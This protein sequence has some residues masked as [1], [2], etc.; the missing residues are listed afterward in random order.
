MAQCGGHRRGGFQTRPYDPST[1]DCEVAETW[2]YR[3]KYNT[4][5]MF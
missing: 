5:R 1:T 3:K 2:E 4:F